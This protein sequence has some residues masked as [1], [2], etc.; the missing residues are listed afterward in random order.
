MKKRIF[1]KAVSFALATVMALSSIL[2][3]YAQEEMAGDL[4]V[5][6]E[7]TILD[8]AEPEETE[9]AEPE[10]E[11]NWDEDSY[12][13]LIVLPNQEDVTYHYESTHYNKDFSTK[14]F[15]ILLYEAGE[16]V[17]LGIDTELDYH[18]M[19]MA[20]WHEYLSKED[21]NFGKAEFVMPELD[22]ELQ[23][24]EPEIQEETSEVV[25]EADPEYEVAEDPAAE[26]VIEAEEEATEETSEDIEE[27]ASETEE[28]PEDF[29]TEEISEVEETTEVE[30]EVENPEISEVSE[31]AS[32]KETE[33][34]MTDEDYAM[35][36]LMEEEM[37]DVFPENDSVH[38]LSPIQVWKWDT[39]FDVK[40]YVPDYALSDYTEITYVEGD[41]DY[42]ASGLSY[43][44][45][46]AA[47]T[48]NPERNW[49]LIL[50]VE[51]VMEQG[52][53]VVG[54]EGYED[55]MFNEQS[56]EFSGIVPSHK[57]ETLHGN[58]YTVYA[59][60]DFDLKDLNLD[61][62]LSFYNVGLV[63]AGDFDS[64]TPGSYE[65]TYE[66]N[67]YYYP[68]FQWRV[69]V[70]IDV[71]EKDFAAGSMTVYVKS[72][73]LRA[74]ASTKD[75]NSAFAGVG[76]NAVSSSPID[77]LTVTSVR[78]EEI[79]PVIS[80]QKNGTMMED[81]SGIVL[82]QQL[83]GNIFFADFNETM[84]IGEDTYVVIVDFPDYDPTANGARKSTGGLERS[85]DEE[86]SPVMLLADGVMTLETNDTIVSKTYYGIGSVTDLGGQ[87]WNY[88]PA[89]WAYNEAK[90]T[91]SD[92]FL[93]KVTALC[94][95]YN[96]KPAKDLP[97]GGWTS[98]YSGHNYAGWP[99]KSYCVSTDATV[100]LVDTTGDGVPNRISVKYHAYGD[101]DSGYQS[102]VG[103]F[104]LSTN[105]ST[106]EL[107]IVKYTNSPNFTKLFSG[108]KIST[109][110]GIYDNKACGS[111]NLVETL[112]FAP[113]D[114]AAYSTATATLEPGKY[115]V[116][117]ISRC[118]GHRDETATVYG[119]FEVKSGETTTVDDSDADRKGI[120]NEAFYF[121]STIL[122]KVDSTTE[123]P[124]AGA[125]F[126]ITANVSGTE[127]SWFFETDSKGQIGYDSGHYLATWNNQKSDSL[128][129]YRSDVGCALPIS[130][131]KI[132][133][134]EAPYGYLLDS[135]EYSMKLSAVKDANGKYT[136]AKLEHDPVIIKEDRDEGFIEIQKYTDANG[137][138][139]PVT[140]AYSLEGAVYGIYQDKACQTTP[141]QSLTTN[142]DGYAKSKAI[143]KGSTEKT[144]YVKEISAPTCGAYELD[145]VVYTATLST[146][147]PLAIVKSVD[148]PKKGSLS[149]EKE[150]KDNI[151]NQK[152]SGIH[153]TMTHENAANLKNL[154]HADAYTDDKGFAKFEN[155]V[156]GTW[157]LEEDPASVPSG[158]KPM[159]PKT[160]VIDGTHKNESFTIVNEKFEGY[161]VI[162]KVDAETGNN[163]TRGNAEFK[164]IDAAGKDV[165]V[166]V[167]DVGK[168]V[169]FK[170]NAEGEVHFTEPLKAGTYILKELSAPVGYVTFEQGV[171]FEISQNNSLNDPLLLTVKNT[172]MKKKAALTKID[173]LTG[174][175]CGA[176]FAFN[177][178]AA[179]D[180]V[181]G[182]GSV[183][184]VDGK[185][186]KAGTVVD[187]I[188]TNADGIA[189][190]KE[191]YLGKY[192]FQEKT[193][194]DGYRINDT[195]YPFELSAGQQ[196]VALG[197]NIT[198]NIQIEDMPL[199]RPIQVM[200]IDADS[201]N[202]CGAGF[203]F[204]IRAVNVVDGAGKV[205]EGYEKGTLLET[206]TT[207]KD[208]IATSQD[209][210]TGTYEVKEKACKA[211][212]VLNQ[213]VF[214]VEVTDDSK[215]IAPVK[216]TVE[217]KPLMK[218][219][220]VTKLDQESGNRC[221]EGFV[222]KVVAAEDIVDASGAVRSVGDTKL[223]KGTVVDTITTNKDG[224]ATSKEMY[225]GKY[226]V[227]ETTVKDGYVVNPNKFD[228]D[229][230]TD[231]KLLTVNLNIENSPLMRPI[232]V[233][234]VDA[235]S[236]NL[237]KEGFTFEI[238]AVSVLDNTG[239]VRK[240][241]EKDAVV[242]TIKTGANGIATSKNL[243]MGTY[244]VT[245]TACAA[246]YT[247]NK[248]VFTV[249]VKDENKTVTPV[250]LI[251]KNEPLKKKISVTKIDKVSGNSCGAGFTF[252]VV[253]AED[254][255]D[256]SG[257][258]RVSGSTKLAKGTVVD[259]ITTGED[260]IATS[261]ELFLGKYYV[262]EATVKEGYVLNS[263]KYSVDLDTD[264]KTLIVNLSIANAPLMRPIQV[265]KLDED[266]KTPC[267]A[268][269]QFEVRSVKVV[270]DKGNVRKGF[271]KGT[272]IET[273]TTDEKGIA[274]T[275]DLYLGTY[276]I[277]ESSTINGYV[278]NEKTYT[279]EVKDEEKTTTPVII[280]IENKPLKKTL[281]VTKIDAETGNHCGSGF[282]FNVVAAEDIKDGSHQIRKGW[283]KDAI[284]DVITT[285]EDGIATSKPLY[286]GKYYVQ[287]IEV[288]DDGYAINRT[289][290]HFELKDE[291]KEDQVM[292][293]PMNIPDNVTTLKIHKIDTVVGKD[294]EGI[295]FRVKAV[296]EADADS[297][298]YTT[299]AKGNITVK[300]LKRSTAYQIQEVKT[301]PGYNLVEEI[302]TFEVDKDGLIDGESVYGVTITN[303]PNEVHI[304]KVDVTNSEELP[305][306]A[307]VITDSE[308]N[309]Y[310]EWISTEEEHVIY[311]MPSGT[312]TL[313]EKTSPD[314]YEVEESIEFEIVDSLVV[315][316]I[317][318]KDSPYRKVEISKRD[319]TND[320]E[321]PGATLVVK[322]AE[323][324]VIDEWVSTEEPHMMDL[325]SGLY[326]LT[327]TIPAEGFVTAETIQFEVIK[328]TAEDYDVMP[329]IM[330]DEV[331]KL[332]ISKKDV[333]TD[334]ELP[335]AHLTIQNEDGEIVEE[336]TSTE[337]EHY[338][339][340]LPIGTYT[341]TEVTA[342]DGYEVAE[343]I[344]FE[345]TDTPEIQHVEMFD[346][347]YREMIISKKDITNSEEIAGAHLQILD[348]NGN[349]VEEW[350]SGDPGKLDELTSAPVVGEE[351]KANQSGKA[352]EKEE[353]TETSTSGKVSPHYMTLP[354]GKYTLVETLP[355]AGYVT[356]SS[357]AFEV[358]ERNT[359]GDMEV[360]T[361]EMFDDITKL[362]ISKKDITNEQE[363][364]GATLVIKDVEGNVVEEW[365]STNE[366]H[367]IE[368]IPIGEYT[369]TEIT[370]PN[371]YEVA[372]TITFKVEDTAEIQHVEMFD[373]PTP[374][375]PKTG[376]NLDLNVVL[377][378]G[379]MVMILL[380]TG[381][382]LIR[383]GKKR[384]R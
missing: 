273:I 357:I 205:R 292:V 310:D 64:N 99:N 351:E 215:S 108:V 315:Q 171:K 203:T 316:K 286:L 282:K 248:T 102:M 151:T 331:T 46:R 180:I 135:K 45:Y 335:G 354:S 18:M 71:V 119:P 280:R 164:I 15:T 186:L 37:L 195:K 183:R 341:L 120:G 75:G 262:Q 236:G 114:E 250:G 73:A 22:L 174:K 366:P 311:E 274:K 365:V 289:R 352:D 285:N 191:L 346:S 92:S 271:E 219:L 106:G 62:D 140:A 184:T 136:T 247:L 291:E 157:T 383:K 230:T 194:K 304:S 333:T 109:S 69:I 308:G 94:E 242:D 301:I 222:F 122:K 142:K 307:L 153:F 67:S 176:G 130:T 65:V 8:E 160:V 246:G 96:V 21:M 143:T 66:V 188:T 378:I 319:I 53:A 55:L 74:V 59:G 244:T 86:N 201:K 33:E 327:E 152:L 42:F 372:E 284:V 314:G 158:Y 212:Y 358:F 348:E 197:E 200:K 245:E 113:S 263:E 302:V 342:P 350:V 162:K 25:D 146:S 337:E 103:S 216:L 38:E 185:A 76:T 300:H 141:L 305:G 154:G 24:M 251:V 312:Y 299:D 269:V 5:E 338:I 226:Y 168:T 32:Y 214:T 87:V 44:T 175:N 125:V 79:Y 26:E 48:E 227:Q 1:K 133:E 356:A 260:G 161:L 112:K 218:N 199:L 84:E 332:V 325:H 131:I 367:Y 179:E 353:K 318:M 231:S 27:E 336:W 58:H 256:A 60:E 127:Y 182:S 264:P 132:Q 28:M 233:K 355:A 181:D 362:E 370:A 368:R 206:L 90:V 190:T 57:E 343:V 287:E 105:P 128:F 375:V 72:G 2:P 297:Q 116:K 279:V 61:Y 330:N 207:G 19:E 189:V 137:S 7:E 47:W 369:L 232:Q 145:P 85:E 277:K 50:P 376:D 272:L 224:I 349:I 126:K 334:E 68:D 329:V 237:C 123:A 255:L 283:E 323:G 89:G 159:K 196:S 243:Y 129:V 296:D 165:E 41:I 281:S 306:A 30:E 6:S 155:L 54:S 257:A 29:E 34:T 347:P 228:F 56:E 95:E 117:E 166:N 235:A 156:Y 193:A 81:I 93:G 261:K 82:N 241:Y 204:E 187:I 110:F 51:V 14:E 361:V 138:K 177:V 35:E 360:Q 88:N 115:Y 344:V 97:T 167:K 118:P 238:K 211:G 220:A 328:T 384:S 278:L 49:L 36:D 150:L 374:T 266:S 225:L 23:L 253:A 221:G 381:I 11:E 208:G 4:T 104:T 276:S 223:V 39:G 139:V 267:G 121:K 98:C 70:T 377:V 371:G 275:K 144:Y 249:E 270:D 379:A 9:K 52:E 63:D 340:R 234:K 91:F 170:T 147:A 298:L 295:V 13:Y 380:G 252:N 210:F 321:L 12:P 148:K 10:T 31:E 169:T 78:N 3:V 217:N 111:D 322:D 345:I 293:I 149:I 240:G 309:V 324:N 258:V 202:R 80:I 229:L 294:L 134:V 320:E 313:T 124:V 303:Q 20:S 172:S 288:N 16:T 259:T 173:Q 43:I 40:S 254:I 213:K 107:K 265:V 359:E 101:S 192:Y 163:I 198:V 100:S 326:T 83:E 317:T 268:G 239:H 382:L 209:L 339:E 363:L 178:V 364:P 373:S 77:F 290:Y 17:K